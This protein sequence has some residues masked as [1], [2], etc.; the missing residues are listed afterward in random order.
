MRLD[1]MSCCTSIK[2]I[3]L[4]ARSQCVHILSR[5]RSPDRS[6]SLSGCVHVWEWMC[7]FVCECVFVYI[8]VCMYVLGVVCVCMY[9]SAYMRIY[10]VCVL[11]VVCMW[12]SVSVCRGWGACIHAYEAYKACPGHIRLLSLSQAISWVKTQFQS[13]P[14]IQCTI[15][16]L[17]NALF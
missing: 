6:W 10:N 4:A 1:V 3:Y 9:V 17:A 12:V 5:M 15:Q 7:V 2:I 14:F 8:Y 16:Y 13:E 11:G